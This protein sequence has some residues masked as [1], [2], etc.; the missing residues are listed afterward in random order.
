MA[1][2]RQYNNPYESKTQ[3]YS[4]YRY[5]SKRYPDKS[6]EEIKDI[7]D[8]WNYKYKRHY[9]KCNKALDNTNGK[10]A[11]KDLEYPTHDPNGI[12][13]TDE[14]YIYYIDKVWSKGQDKYLSIM[15]SSKGKYILLWKRFG[16]DRTTPGERKYEKYYINVSNL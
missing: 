8:N 11:Y 2:N 15:N 14:R 16:K 12:I 7:V 5:L 4:T 1:K 6:N 9:T 10:P 13:K 3:Q